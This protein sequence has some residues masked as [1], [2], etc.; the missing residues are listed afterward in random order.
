[1]KGMNVIL[2]LCDA[3]RADRDY[4][5]FPRV[6]MDGYAVRSADLADASRKL[7][8]VGTVYAGDG[9]GPQIAA[10]ECLRIMTGAVLPGGADAVIRQEDSSC[11]ENRVGFDTINA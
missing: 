7:A 5:P 8:L 10:G 11:H 3:L 2:V 1:M 9:P 6:T 4:P